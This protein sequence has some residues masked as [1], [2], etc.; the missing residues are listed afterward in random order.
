MQIILK[1]L[2]TLMA[3]AVVGLA[4]TNST[5]APLWVLDTK[6]A[7]SLGLVILASAVIGS[8]CSALWLYSAM[9]KS[10]NQALRFSHRKE[11]A[12]VRQEASEDQIKA[13]QAKVKTL[14]LALEKALKA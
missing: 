1:V 14:E 5:L 2:S 8:I 11:Q 9:L 6:L 7:L 10:Q 3:L 12:Q 13:L 4:Y